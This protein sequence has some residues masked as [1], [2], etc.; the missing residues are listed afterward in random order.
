MNTL[1]EYN[2][3]KDMKYYIQDYYSGLDITKE[4]Y[5]RYFK[6]LDDAN[7]FLES[8]NYRSYNDDDNFFIVAEDKNGNIIPIEQ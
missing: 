7:D 8:L 5:T 2:K 6:T 4:G 3:D 1:T